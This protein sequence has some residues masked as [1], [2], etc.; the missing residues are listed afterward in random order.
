MLLMCHVLYLGIDHEVPPVP[1]NPE[2]P[3]CYLQASEL[4]RDKLT[5]PFIYEVGTCE[6][7]ACAF[8]YGLL[9]IENSE[10]QI[11]DDACRQSARWLFDLLGRHLPLE[12]YSCWT[13]DEAKPALQRIDTTLDQFCDGR[14][15]EL[16]DRVL[17]VLRA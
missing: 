17:I 3:A 11:A 7:C 9:P 2:K 1:F 13:G 6:G 12:L 5:R 16:Q 10:D 4:V 14:W 8:E 15:F